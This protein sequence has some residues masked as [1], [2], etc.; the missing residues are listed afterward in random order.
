MNIYLMN[1]AAEEI[2]IF[3]KQITFIDMIGC[4]DT[5]KIAAKNAALSA[6]QPRP[7]IGDRF[8]EIVTAL[9]VPLNHYLIK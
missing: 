7:F 2:E 3:R 5:G 4:E 8:K 6:E 9:Y 1:V